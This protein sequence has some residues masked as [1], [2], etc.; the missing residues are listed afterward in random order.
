MKWSKQ[1]KIVGDRKIIQS[2]CLM[3][4]ITKKDGVYQPM[5]RRGMQ[6]VHLKTSTDI[7]EAKTTIEKNK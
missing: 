1:R 4:C 6:W 3:Y 2:D 7:N 5:K